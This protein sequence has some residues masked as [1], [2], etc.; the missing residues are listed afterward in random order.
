MNPIPPLPNH[1]LTH[2]GKDKIIKNAL[3]GHRF[4]FSMNRCGR[5]LLFFFWLSKRPE[6]PFFAKCPLTKMIINKYCIPTRISPPFRTSY[7][8]T[9]SHSILFLLISYC[10]IT[11]EKLKPKALG[12]GQWRYRIFLISINYCIR[13][14]RWGEKTKGKCLQ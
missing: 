7:I 9:E 14:P 10:K 2:T 6:T 1:S 11:C 4:D 8:S 5:A 12:K 3:G 13:A